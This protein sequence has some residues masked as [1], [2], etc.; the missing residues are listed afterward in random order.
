MIRLCDQYALNFYNSR[1]ITASR[2]PSSYWL[3]RVHLQP[4]QEC[5]AQA[6][7][8]SS[9]SRTHRRISSNRLRLENQRCHRTP[10]HHRTTGA[11]D[12]IN[13]TQ[14]DNHEEPVA[15]AGPDRS[16]KHTSEPGRRVRSGP[17]MAPSRFLRSDQ[18]AM[19]GVHCRTQH[20]P[21]IPSASAPLPYVCEAWSPGRRTPVAWTSWTGK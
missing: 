2:I 9:P 8:A 6:R 3:H 17:W 4:W 15:V 13:E 5:L 14:P 16:H 11:A 10:R 20:R 12:R 18:Q 7:H 1:K 19:A 21:F